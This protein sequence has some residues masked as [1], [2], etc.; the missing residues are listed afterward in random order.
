MMI[1]HYIKIAF[2]NLMKY[3][4]QTILSVIGLAV[5][6]VC[7]AYSLIWLRYERTFDSFHPE[8]DRIYR[9]YEKSL[10]GGLLSHTC[11][12]FSLASAMKESFPEVEVAAA[13]CQGHAHSIEDQSEFLDQIAV[14]SAFLDLFDVHILAG[15]RHF[16]D[17][18]QEV[19]ITPATARKLFGTEQVLGRTL[20]LVNTGDV[21]ND[22]KK[23]ITALVSEWK[24]HSNMPY[25]LL[26][27]IRSDRKENKSERIFSLCFRLRE[28]TD[29][30]AF[31]FAIRSRRP[32]FIL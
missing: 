13:F 10:L 4:I 8:A 14:D 28:D 7:F 15:N 21:Q 12:P 18:D 31:L 20:E 25:E 9:V 3:R 5:G 24:G 30:A 1:L 19:A 2:R 29:T 16:L 11:C 23:T 22:G 6:F 26:T 32:D 27:G 17:S